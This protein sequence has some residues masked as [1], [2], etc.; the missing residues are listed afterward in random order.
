MALLEF[1]HTGLLGALNMEM[2]G[3]LS[4]FT[5]QGLANVVYSLGL[6]DY[7]CP[8]LLRAIADHLPSRWS[9]LSEQHLSNIAC[10]FG[11]LGFLDSR[12]LGSFGSVL[13]QGRASELTSQGLCMTVYGLAVA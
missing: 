8:P 10:G 7:W 11:L 5:G 2:L 13:R 12:F 1:S 6:L 3:R 4:E 9:E